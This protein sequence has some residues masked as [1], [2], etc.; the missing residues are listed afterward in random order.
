MVINYNQLTAIKICSTSAGIIIVNIDFNCYS[1]SALLY[2]L[3]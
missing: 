3:S 1:G 2:S